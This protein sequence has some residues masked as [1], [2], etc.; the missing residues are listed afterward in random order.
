MRQKRAMDIYIIIYV[1]STKDAWIIRITNRKTEEQLRYGLLDHA[2][3]QIIIYIRDSIIQKLSLYI[4]T[5]GRSSIFEYGI[6]TLRLKKRATRPSGQQ[7]QRREKMD[8]TI[9]VLGGGRPWLWTTG[10]VV[11]G[12]EGSTCMRDVM[13]EERRQRVRGD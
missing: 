11:Q 1:L 4:Y 2:Y 12:W 3:D 13:K 6:Q 9:H 8:Q 7:Q 5:V 10:K